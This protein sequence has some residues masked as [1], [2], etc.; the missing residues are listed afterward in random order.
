MRL[1]NKKRRMKN[2]LNNMWFFKHF[3]ISLTGTLIKL[4]LMQ[5]NHLP[6]NILISKNENVTFLLNGVVDLF[7]LF[8]VALN[9]NNSSSNY[10]YLYQYKWGIGHC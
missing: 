3:S 10:C 1:K 9:Q 7:Y 6:R 2:I 8:D 4:Y 5:Q